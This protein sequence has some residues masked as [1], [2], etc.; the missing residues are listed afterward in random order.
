[1]IGAALVGRLLAAGFSV[2]LWNRT[3]E[4]L[5]RLV[6]DGALAAV[7]VA[8]AV[9][10]AD[11]ICMCVSD[12]RAAEQVLFGM[13]GVPAA[14]KPPEVLIDFSTIGPAATV[15]MA[16]RLRATCGTAWIDAPVSGGVVGAEAGKLVVFCGGEEQDFVRI[17]PVLTPLALRVTRFGGVGSGQS[18]K[19]CNQLIVA[20]TVAAIAEAISLASAAT[21]DPVRLVDALTGGFADSAPLQIF[22]RRMAARQVEPKLSEIALMAKDIALVIDLARSYGMAVPLASSTSALY[23]HACRQGIAHE[24]LAALTAIHA[25]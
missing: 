3:R 2:R 20:A 4:K 15:E 22:G 5:A 16:G 13:R 25:R 17:Q 10:S 1:M 19:L 24:D 18:A 9:D 12:A 23:D 14:R 11:A 8:E 21:L 6:A 7:T